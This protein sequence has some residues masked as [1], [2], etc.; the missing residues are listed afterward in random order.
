MKKC[1]FCAEDIQDAAVVCKHCGR[2]LPAV[3]Q[4][5]AAAS[6][7][8]S[9]TTKGLLG[10]L[11]VLL[12]FVVLL[13]II[14]SIVFREETQ[15]PTQPA[16]TQAQPP[17]PQLDAG[18]ILACRLFAPLIKDVDAGRLTTA[19][20]RDGLKKVY[21]QARVWPESEVARTSSALLELFTTEVS[22]GMS[23]AERDRISRERLLAVVRACSP[24]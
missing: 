2:D 24:T 3:P 10:C 1:P 23:I 21:E 22:P 15:P 8:L 12:V 20:F 4:K 17:R 18:A 6:P 9:A 7:P 13:A 11:G 14:G 19:E 5:V 16:R